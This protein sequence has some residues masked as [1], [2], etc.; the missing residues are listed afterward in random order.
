MGGVFCKALGES[1]KIMCARPRE[2]EKR[3]FTDE[4][5]ERVIIEFD[6]LQERSKGGISVGKVGRKGHMFDAFSKQDFNFTDL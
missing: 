6:S 3:D 1:G 4:N 5:N 2:G